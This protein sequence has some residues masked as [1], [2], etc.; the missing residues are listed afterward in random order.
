MILGLHGF[1]QSGKDTMAGILIE[2]L[3][4]RRIAFADIL[5]EALYRLDPVVGFTNGELLTVTRVVDEI[6]WEKAKVQYSEVRRLLQVIGTE[7]GRD[8]I[9]EN[10]WVNLAMKGVGVNDKVVV[11]DVR[12]PNEIDAINKLNGVLIKIRRPDLGPINNHVSDSG[13]PDEM[14][15]FIID[16]EGSVEDFNNKTLNMFSEFQKVALFKDA[17]PRYSDFKESQE[18]PTA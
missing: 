10:V 6:G 17:P 16:N 5:R 3:G 12:Y 15:D 13:L 7:V 14:F 11:T 8:L 9:D 1:A 2:K 4:Y 18:Q